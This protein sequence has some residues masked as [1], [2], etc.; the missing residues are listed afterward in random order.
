MSATLTENVRIAGDMQEKVEELRAMF[1]ELSVPEVKELLNAHGGDL[2]QIV[3]KLLLQPSPP[4]STS[5][6]DLSRTQEQTSTTPGNPAVSAL[7]SVSISAS[8]TH[9]HQ[10]ATSISKPSGTDSQVS[11]WGHSDAAQTAHSNPSVISSNRDT[12]PSKKLEESYSLPLTPIQRPAHEAESPEEPRSPPQITPSKP[13]LRSISPP[14]PRLAPAISSSNVIP[15]HF[16]PIGSFSPGSNSSRDDVRNASLTSLPADLPTNSSELTT[17]PIDHSE[18]HPFLSVD[19]PSKSH[20]LLVHPTPSTPSRD[21][22]LG[23]LTSQSPYSTTS[24]SPSSQLSGSLSASR[25]N[26]ERNLRLRAAEAQFQMLMASVSEM[27]GAQQ[28]EIDRQEA[29]IHQL[30]AE[31]AALTAEKTTWVGRLQTVSQASVHLREQISRQNSTIDQLNEQVQARDNTIAAL[32]AKIASFQP[33]QE[34]EALRSQFETALQQQSSQQQGGDVRQAMELFA[35]TFQQAFA[36]SLLAS[37][38]PQPPKE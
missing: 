27:D 25:L 8:P 28:Q 29:R 21:A 2:M 35:A 9:S 11:P 23:P 20:L 13:L 24:A 22:S 34:A 15:Q 7:G 6:N 5:T 16:D 38:Q 14:K 10:S 12:T 32:N 3:D 33:I 1:P 18:S 31:L 19:R 17:N 4:K 26:D 30:E 37:Q 36:A